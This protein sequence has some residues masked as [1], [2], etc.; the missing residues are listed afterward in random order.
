MSTPFTTRALLKIKRTLRELDPLEREFVAAWPRIDAID[1]WLLPEEARWLFKAARKLR[2]GANI[3]E[4]GS[5]KGRS[6][7]CLALGCG[8]TRKKVFALDSF[9]GGPDLD[10]Y[11]S[12]QEFQDN[13]RAL[14]VTQH[15]EILRGISWDLAKTWNQPIHFLFIDGSHIYEHVLAD[16]HSFFPHVVP[17]GIVA[18]HDV[19]ESHPGVLKAWRETF[20]PSLVRVGRRTSLGFGRKPG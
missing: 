7:C 4:I 18:F 9:D 2:D 16:F 1:G 12:F 8:H 20:E 17:G 13:L 19:H 14:C 15:V 3:V 6:T 5:Y 10:Q 11:D